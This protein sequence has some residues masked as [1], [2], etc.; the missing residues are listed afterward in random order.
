MCYIGCMTKADARPA[1]VSKTTS[2]RLDDLHDRVVAAAAVAGVGP[3]TWLRDLARRELGAAVDHQDSEAHTPDASALVYRAWLNADMTAQLDV[4]KKRDGF[5][6]RAAVLRALIE[7]V[8]ITD[9]SSG[10]RSAVAS[11]DGASERP[12]ALR[13]AVD[14]LGASNHQ[15][16]AIARN[17]SG[18]A[19][20]LREG[21]GAARVI[22]RIRLV[23][24]VDAINGH[25]RVASELLGDLRPLLKR[26]ADK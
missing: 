17:V 18:I 1:R 4:R 3:S 7:G 8:G 22:D 6:S 24:T 14:A 11:K 5:R 26:S 20:A 19:K 16:V 2:V 23:E 25:V 13:E 15:L 21:D 9:G 10:A 12:G